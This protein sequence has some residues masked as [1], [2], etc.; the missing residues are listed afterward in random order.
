LCALVPGFRRDDVR[1]G[2]MTYGV[3]GGGLWRLGGMTY[4]LT[5]M[6]VRAGI[7]MASG[8][9]EGAVEFVRQRER[10]RGRWGTC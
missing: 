4:G 9:S 8:G 5:V 2:G 1:G 7:G 10:R 6:G 3:G